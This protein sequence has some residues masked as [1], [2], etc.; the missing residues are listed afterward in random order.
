[1]T[2][3]NSLNILTPKASAF[4]LSDLHH[5]LSTS[6][7]DT[8]CFGGVLD[9][10]WLSIDYNH[11]FIW[12]GRSSAIESSFISANLNFNFL[13]A[14]FSTVLSTGFLLFCQTLRGRLLFC[15][16]LLLKICCLR[17]VKKTGIFILIMRAE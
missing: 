6:F 14:L 12:I 17:D 16:D 11:R 8:C 15:T 3:K 7:P 5:E 9:I 4:L 13:A 2:V 1:M 10:W